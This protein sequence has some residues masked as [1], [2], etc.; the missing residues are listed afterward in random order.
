MECFYRSK[1]F[2]ENGKPSRGYRQRMFREWRN[3]G[4]FESTEQRISDQARAIRKNGWLSELVFEVIKRSV[5]EEEEREANNDVED[6]REQVDNE[7]LMDV[8]VEENMVNDVNV[9][10]N[11]HQNGGFVT[12]D[13]MLENILSESQR[14]I[15]ENLREIH[16]EKKTAEGISFKK[17]DKNKL[18]REMNRVNQ[19]IRHIETKNITETN[20]L[21]KAAT[22]WVG[23]QLGLKKTEFRA[24]KAPRWKRRIEDD[25]KRIRKDVNILARELRGELKHKKSEKLQRLE[26]KYRGNKK[27]IKTV[28]EELKQRMIAR[29][30]KIKGY[31]QRINQFRQNRIF[32]VDQKKNLQGTEWR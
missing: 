29:S 31:D 28:V 21:I 23:E 25:I 11:D 9:E 5:I 20:E 24:K 14:E 16:V 2:D 15:V 30:A 3:R 22:V 18:K 8:D 12:K 10:E 1:P 4:G 13:R 19:V 32:S 26:E 27:G 6:G 17:V 7:N